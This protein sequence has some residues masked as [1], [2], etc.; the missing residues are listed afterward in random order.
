MKMGIQEVNDVNDM[1]SCLRRNDKKEMKKDG[2][3]SEF[4]YPKQALITSPF[5]LRI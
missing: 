1:D 5:F 4:P 3:V 2:L